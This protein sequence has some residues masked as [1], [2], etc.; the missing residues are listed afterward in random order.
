MVANY[1]AGRSRRTWC[2]RTAASAR[3]PPKSAPRFERESAT[4]ERA[5]CALHHADPS[6]RFALVCDLGLDEVLVYRMDRAKL[7]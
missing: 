7:R 2:R 3:R 1:N 5:A 6:N 4:A